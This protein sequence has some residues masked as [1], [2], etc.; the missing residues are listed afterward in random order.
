MTKSVSKRFFFTIITSLFRS[1][2]GFSTG[3]LLARFLGPKDYGNMSFLLGTF[4]AIRQLLDIGSAQAFFTFMSQRLRSKFF[5]LMYFT[6]LT[7]QF[8]IVI[9]FI[10]LLFPA[11]WIQT[12]WHGEHRLLI[13]M[14][15]AAAFLQNSVWPSVQQAL[16]AQR[17]TYKAQGIGIT[18]VILHIVAVYILWL[19]GKI[20]LYSVFAAIFIEYLIATFIAYRFLEFSTS[21]EN[22]SEILTSGHIFRMFIKYCTPIILYSWIGFIHSFADTWLLQNYGGSVKQ[23]YYAVSA[24][25]AAVAL[26]A[27]ASISNIFYKEIAEAYHK[28]DMEQVKRIYF[29][30]SRSLFL[31]GAIISCFLIP[32][33]KDLLQNI[34]GDSYVSG[35]ITLGIMFLYPIHQ[36]MGQIGG[37]V[38]FATEYVSLQA[39][40]GIIFMLISIIVSYLVLAPASALIPGMNLAS[41]G[42]A[43]KMLIMQFLQV[44]FMAFCIARIF[45][46]SFDWVY[47]PVSIF[48]CLG[49]GWLSH[50]IVIYITDSS[51]AFIFS[52]ALGGLIYIIFISAFI[53]LFPWLTGLSR[54][55]LKIA[56]DKLI[57]TFVKPVN[58]G[59]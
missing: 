32:W 36:S 34:L 9:F 51:L 40:I 15:F 52:L 50:F 13:V 2:L 46:S 44:N 6:W 4:L 21:E 12:I 33:T 19:F 10:G 25:F 14:A 49:L 42:L 59:A 8:F 5:I 38:L 11:S 54:S 18:L 22:E 37:S 30:V 16:E 47:Q 3:M 7:L 1:L 53:Y 56:L 27:T 31:I 35:Y 48:G 26:L 43:A 39:K 55:E 20:G 58:P 24:Q 29:K 28:Q 45:K 41:E 17:L 23:A 57:Q